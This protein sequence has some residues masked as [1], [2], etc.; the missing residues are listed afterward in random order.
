MRLM[1]ASVLPLILIAIAASGCHREGDSTSQLSTTLR[2]IVAGPALVP[3]Q[4]AVWT[5]V[6]KFYE[7]R[8][9]APAWV[10]EGSTSAAAEALQALRSAPAHGFAPEDYGEP[11]LTERLARL[12]Q[13]KSVR[14]KPDT[15]TVSNDAS[16]RLRQL[17]ELDAG[18]TAALLA[19]SRDVAAGRTTPAALDRRW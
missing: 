7:Q 8:E 18:L 12:R 4:A 15:T 17:A 6:R 2:Q 9:G 19:F 1:R 16:D 13:S 10:S 11:H 3:G 5:D 14:L